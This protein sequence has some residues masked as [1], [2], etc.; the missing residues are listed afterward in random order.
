METCILRREYQ[1]ITP[2][3]TLLLH[4]IH[5]LTT[6]PSIEWTEQCEHEFPLLW[7]IHN[8]NDVGLLVAW[9]LCF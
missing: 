3:D 5:V 1:Y 6:V 2:D 4:L 7:K 8:H 9:W